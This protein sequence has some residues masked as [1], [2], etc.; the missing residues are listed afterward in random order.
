MNR[1]CYHADESFFSKDTGKYQLIIVTENEPGY[2][3]ASEWGSLDNAKA[4][5]QILNAANGL[6]AD[7]VLNIRTSSMAASF[8]DH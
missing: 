4:K 2:T 1:M 5:A 6:S 3:V 8:G 7:D